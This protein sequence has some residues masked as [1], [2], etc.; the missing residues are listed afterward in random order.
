M[1]GAYLHFGTTVGL[2]TWQLLCCISELD[3]AGSPLATYALPA[4][5]GKC[6]GQQMPP[7]RLRQIRSS[8]HIITKH[9]RYG[10]NLNNFFG[11]LIPNTLLV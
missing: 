3:S 2:V 6:P 5:R 11:G 1:L 10:Q 9:F 8:E 4:F 7:M